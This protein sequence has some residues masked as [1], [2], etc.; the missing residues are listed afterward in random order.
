MQLFNTPIPPRAIPVARESLGMSDAMHGLQGMTQ[1][2]AGLFPSDDSGAFSKPYLN[3]QPTENAF[4]SA[5]NQS[6][7]FQTAA[8][9]AAAGAMGA[10]RKGVTEQSTAQY[11][12]QSGLNEYMANILDE[13]GMGQNL[14]KM[15]A[16][17]G[18]EPGRAK[19]ENDVMTQQ[20]MAAGQAPELGAEKAES[21]YYRR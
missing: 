14:M 9:Q 5:Q 20:A 8:P 12:A 17:M 11:R 21:M 1:P 2:N 15:N 16:M 18:T 4:L 10:V 19:L 3:A 6:Q 7:N 13:S